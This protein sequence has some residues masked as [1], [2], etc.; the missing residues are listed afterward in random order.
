MATYNGARYL[1]EQLQSFLDQ[2]RQPDELIITDDASTDE[3]LDIIHNFTKRAPFEV[4][5]DQNDQNLGLTQNF[6]KALSYTTGDL[7]FLSDQ[8]DVWF[9]QKIEV[10]VEIASNSS[11]L[12]IMNDAALTDAEL[13]EVGLTKLGQIHSAGLP[14]HA[15][16]MGCCA[17]IKRDLLDLCKPIPEGHPAHDSWI[18]G[19]ADCMKV[20][21]IVNQCYQYY[22]RHEANKSQF[23]AN[24]TQKVTKW[25][26]RLNTL[27]RLGKSNDPLHCQ[28][29]KQIIQRLEYIKVATQHFNNIYLQNLQDCEEHL[30]NKLKFFDQRAIVHS[31]PLIQR[32]CIVPFLWIKGYYPGFS[33]LKLA[34]RDIIFH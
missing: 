29:R 20:K 22:R 31:K 30:K 11:A 13:N 14:D 17:A 32:V 12:V 33:G 10:M 1:E 2:T 18:I 25:H 27:K 7:V 15:F 24:R 23:I 34:A 9:P 5:W 28:I 16:V 21:K 4:W 26:V 6:N 8:D 3:T 19:F